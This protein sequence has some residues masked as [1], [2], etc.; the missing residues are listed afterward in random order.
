MSDE[1][2]MGSLRLTLGRETVDEDVSL[3]LNVIPEVVRDLRAM[4]SGSMGNS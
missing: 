3:V 1:R 2:A 4:S